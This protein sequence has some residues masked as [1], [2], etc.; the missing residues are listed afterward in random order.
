MNETGL[1]ALRIDMTMLSPALRTS[2]IRAWA[3]GLDRLDHA[4]GQAELRHQLAQA[5]EAPE[6]GR[7]IVAGELDQQQRVRRAAHEAVDQRPVSG[8][9]RPSSMIVRSTSST[10]DGSS[11]TIARAAAM[12]W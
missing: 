2:Q 10:A 9:W 8:N 11:S 3:V 6:L 7:P 4:V 5:G 12:A 1:P